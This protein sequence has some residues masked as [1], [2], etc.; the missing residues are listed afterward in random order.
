MGNDERIAI[1]AI[2]IKQLDLFKD[3]K[4]PI[5]IWNAEFGKLSFLSIQK[6]HLNKSRFTLC[7]SLYA[8]Q[9]QVLKSNYTIICVNLVFLNH[10]TETP[11]VHFHCNVL[12]VIKGSQLDANSP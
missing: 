3:K 8:T 5:T 10:S 2:Y 9:K 7:Y 6:P 4:S 1:F 11:P 12:D